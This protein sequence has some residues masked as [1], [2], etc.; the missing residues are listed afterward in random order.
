VASYRQTVLTAFKEVED[1][2]AALRFLEREA[3]LQEDAVRSSR[4]TVAITRNQYQAGI[5]GYLNVLSAQNVELTDQRTA[6]GI[7]GRRMNA[8]VLLI[9]AAGG[10]WE[11]AP[12][13]S[14]G[15]PLLRD[16]GS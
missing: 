11:G 5:V 13:H 2:L 12:V 16:G 3:K 1:N 6:I 4:E 9:K 7:L 14:S 10:R 15:P 8:A